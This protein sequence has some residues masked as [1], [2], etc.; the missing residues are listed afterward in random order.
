MIRAYSTQDD[1]KSPVGMSVQQASRRAELEAELR[2]SSSDDTDTND[3]ALLLEMAQQLIPNLEDH[4]LVCDQRL[5]SASRA[6]WLVIGS[7]LQ[8]QGFLS[9]ADDVFFYQRSELIQALEEGIGIPKEEVSHRRALQDQFRS[10]LPPLYLGLKPESLTSP[11]DI[12]AEGAAQQSVKGMAASP[13]VYRGRARV[14]QSLDQASSL[15]NG[16]IL[17][18]RALT[19]PWTPFFGIVGA[20]VTNSGGVI[21]HGAVVAREFGIPAV[22]G[23]G[24]GTDIIRDGS[25][26]T[27][28]GTAGEVFIE[29][30]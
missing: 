25:I 22:V 4:N 27:V 24:N 8:K 2:N 5:V 6:R 30:Q 18:A 14:I 26:V 10:S 7:H 20:I 12:P 11:D 19:P 16:D 29:L 28:D 23:T 21:S 1:S 9:V 3:L 17:V 15:K 13:G